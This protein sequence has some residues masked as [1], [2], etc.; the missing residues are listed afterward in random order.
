[1][2]ENYVQMPMNSILVTTAWSPLLV[3][4][5]Y[6]A[7]IAKSVSYLDQVIWSTLII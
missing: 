6:P 5:N 2:Q 1:M 7:I 4:L 3:I